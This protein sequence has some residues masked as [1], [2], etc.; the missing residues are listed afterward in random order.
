MTTEKDRIR[1]RAEEARYLYRFGKISREQAF[2]EV[3]PYID[4]VNTT[5]REKSEKYGLKFSSVSVVWYC[6]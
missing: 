3:K 1:M 4:L 6:R 5:A 2:K